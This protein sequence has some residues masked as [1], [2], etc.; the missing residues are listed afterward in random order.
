MG[1]KKGEAIGKT[2]K[3]WALWFAVCTGCTLLDN[4]VCTV[5]MYLIVVHLDMYVRMSLTVVYVRTYCI[6]FIVSLCTVCTYSHTFHT[7]PM[8]N[9]MKW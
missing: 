5:H 4:L 9:L 6:S 1:W 7:K 2:N 3:G 8:K